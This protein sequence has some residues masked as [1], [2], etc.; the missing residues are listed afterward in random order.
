IRGVRI[1]L[2]E[3][4]FALL[5]Y[6]AVSEGHVIVRDAKQDGLPGD[7]YLVAYVVVDGNVSVADLKTHMNGKLPFFMQPQYYVFLDTLPLTPNGK[8]DRKRLPAP[9]YQAREFVAPQTLTEQTLADIW[10]EVLGVE[11]VGVLDN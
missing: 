7:E 11:R 6:A 1:E 4:E 8:I 10:Q 5:Q 2:A 9:E 3:I